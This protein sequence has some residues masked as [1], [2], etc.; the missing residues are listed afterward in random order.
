M[1]YLT[2][3]LGKGRLAK[4][5]LDL[6]EKIGIT[7]EEMKDKDSRKL[8]FVNEELKLKFFLAKGP[9]VPTYVEYGA[10]DIGIVGE[11]TIMEEQRKLY[12][13]LDL[14]FGKCRMCVCGPASA[15]ELL[16]HQ[17]QI[18]VATKYPRIAKDYFYN[19]KHQTVEIIK[20]N[21]SIELAPIVGLSE[22]I[23]DI[24]ETGTTLR[25]NGLEV[26]EEVCPLSARVVV[27][28][29]SMRME[30]ERITKILTDLKSVL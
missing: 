24:V 23:V 3:A 7:C 22:V 11:D 4:T 26:L 15:K 1:R 14:G 8:I 18:R 25:E 29:V 19:K 2:F 10:A 16:L 5:A 27:N 9:D 30:N 21:G 20:L 17:E 13:V 6:F 28:Q 12:E